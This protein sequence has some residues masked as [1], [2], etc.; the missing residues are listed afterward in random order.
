[1]DVSKQSHEDEAKVTKNPVTET[2][3]VEVPLTREE[4]SIERDLQVVKQKHKVQSNQ[5]RI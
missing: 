1:V 4:V 3:T 2:K 5:K